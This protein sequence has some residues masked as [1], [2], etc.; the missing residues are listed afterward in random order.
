MKNAGPH[1]LTVAGVYEL[2]HLVEWTTRW[3]D[4]AGI[5][6]PPWLVHGA[7]GLLLAITTSLLFWKFTRAAARLL[8]WLLSQVVIFLDWSE[9]ALSAAGVFCM[10]SLKGLARR[11]LKRL[12]DSLGE[13]G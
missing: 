10:Q 3:I 2:D 9:A 11:A 12:M 1:F 5:D 13:D 6:G 7:A 4:A 8:I